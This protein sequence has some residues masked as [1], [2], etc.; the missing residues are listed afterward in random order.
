MP[1][2]GRLTSLVA[3]RITGCMQKHVVG[4]DVA[5]RYMLTKEWSQKS[6]KAY[7]VGLD[8]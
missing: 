2:P 7:V 3:L 8:L 5:R 6:R 4:S 1:L